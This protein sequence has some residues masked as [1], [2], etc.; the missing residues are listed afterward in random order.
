ML[1]NASPRLLSLYASIAVA[2]VFFAFFTIFNFLSNPPVQWV[3]AFG[4][5]FLV[6]LITYIIILYV[7]AKYIYRKIKLIYKSIH[8]FK[9]TTK[10]NLNVVDL[11]HDIIGE[12]EDEVAEWAADQA[13]EIATLK[14]LEAYR[15]EFLGNVSH[16]LKTP[17]FTIQGY[18]LTLL[19]GALYDE[20]INKKYL[21]KAAKNVERLQTIVEDL[22]TISKM[23]SGKLI[24]EIEEFDIKSLA[25]EV[26]DELEIQA[27]KRKVKLNFKEGANRT[28]LVEADRSRI[29]Q[30][31]I[32]LITNSIKYGKESGNTKISFYDMDKYILVEVSDD[33][34]GIE[35]KHLSHLFDRFYRVDRSRS[36]SM[37]GSGLGLAIVKHII[38][39]HQQT[40]NVRSSLGAGS[41][42]G[43]TLEKA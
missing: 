28:F 1:K 20:N 8:K 3:T 25:E 32:N 12:V 41:T 34:D 43:F 30:V 19:D 18:L 27:S 21:K 15:R 11:S 17:I 42:F 5:A 37:G 36:R 22:D 31:L 23:E 2:I 24:L 35:E 10:K 9:R 39:A 40:I 14:S 6:F 29:R 33:G 26:F 7:L 16:E 4:L 38:E 13:N